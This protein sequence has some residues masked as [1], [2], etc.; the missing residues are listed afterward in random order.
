M[1]EPKFKKRI[2]KKTRPDGTVKTRELAVPSDE[3]RR[4]HWKMLRLLTKLDIPMPHAT[5]GLRGKSVLDNIEPHRQNTHFYLTDLRSAYPSVDINLLLSTVE[6]PV[7][8]ARHQ[9]EVKDF[10]TNWG[11]TPVVPGLPQGA[12]A[13]PFLFNLFC[14]P[15][16]RTLGEFCEHRH[17]T[18][19]R[20][21]DD[22]TFSSRSEIGKKTRRRIR[23]II[24]DTIGI[25]INLRKTQVYDLN[26]GPITVTGVSLYPDR[27]VAATP[28]LLDTASQTFREIGSRAAAQLFVYEDEFKEDIGR[29]HGYHGVVEQ[30][31]DP[32]A[33]ITHRLFREYRAA[34]G[35]LGISG[36]G[37]KQH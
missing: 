32:E 25:P 15:L 17:I 35:A 36:G 1:P 21:L 24:D 13:S 18:Y 3:T 12:P 4:E 7:I 31:S 19:T 16:D 8:P 29:L 28:A 20:Y 26:N 11:T 23:H 33:M 27:R 22:L 5:G 14:L 2:T 10:I 34:L 9:G 37:Q 6:T 30:L